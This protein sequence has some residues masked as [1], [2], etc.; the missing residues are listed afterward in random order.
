M[1]TTVQE[2]PIINVVAG[3]VTVSSL[4]VSKHFEKQHKHVLDAIQRITQESSADFHEPN[5]RPTV[6]ERENPSGGKPITSPAYNLTRDGFSLLAMG[7]TG[8]KALQ[9]KIRYIEAFNVMEEALTSRSTE[10]PQLKELGQC[11]AKE[12]RALAGLA[13]TVAYLEM[14]EFKEVIKDMCDLAGVADIDLLSK[15]D[16]NKVS[17]YIR[18][19]LYTFRDDPGEARVTPVQL[20]VIEGLKDYAAL[21]QNSEA[22]GGKLFDRNDKV[23][24]YDTISHGEANKLIN[25]LI[26]RIDI[27]TPGYDGGE[28]TGYC[29]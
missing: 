17:E 12:I 16:Y 18:C 13:K 26:N 2:S 24:H 19:R 6:I 14:R 27:F 22:W 20:G 29:L 3:S 21:R 7:F 11:S 1:E 28:T 8:K 23:I 5:F 9:W 10:A 15:R 4:D 25:I